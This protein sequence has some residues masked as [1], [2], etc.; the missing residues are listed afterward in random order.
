MHI[1]DVECMDRLQRLTVQTSI[2]EQHTAVYGFVAFGALA[3]R[4]RLILE[5]VRDID[6]CI[7]TNNGCWY[8]HCGLSAFHSGY[9]IQDASTK[10]VDTPLMLILGHGYNLVVCEFA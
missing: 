1:C 8:V 9:I 3:H 6:T 7:F 2:Q 5:G 10:I 4:G